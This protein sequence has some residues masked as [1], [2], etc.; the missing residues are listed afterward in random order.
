[1][2]VRSP[3]TTTALLQQI[4]IKWDLVGPTPQTQRVDQVI[5]SNVALRHSDHALPIATR[6]E[7]MA[8]TWLGEISSCSCFTAL[9]GPAWVLLSEICKP[10]CGLSVQ[11]FLGVAWL[12]PHRSPQ[13]TLE[14]RL[15]SALCAYVKSTHHAHAH[16]LGFACTLDRLTKTFTALFLIER[17]TRQALTR[18][19]RGFRGLAALPHAQAVIPPR[20]HPMLHFLF[21]FAEASG[22]GR[23][24][25]ATESGEIGGRE[26]AKNG[27]AIK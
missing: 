3:T 11:C 6:C 26:G 22:A 1:M 12:G 24:R 19:H 25:T 5:T 2:I 9:P 27:K 23:R 10:F 4:R 8:C 14:S 17:T 7:Y 13:P 18:R 20:R 15:S 21:G 16:T